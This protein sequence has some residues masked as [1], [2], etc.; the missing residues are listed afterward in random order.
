MVQTP[1]E[2]AP[3]PGQVG[4]NFL[5]NPP[6]DKTLRA[7]AGGGV[8]VDRASHPLLPW[9]LYL[10]IQSHLWVVVKSIKGEGDF[11]SCGE[12]RREKSLMVPMEQ[13]AGVSTKILGAEE[14]VLRWWRNRK[15][16]PLSPPQIHQKNI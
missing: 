8:G 12:G 9:P 3:G 16:R 14:A 11:D 1:A 5:T 4:S 6:G 7:G 15:G 2:R 13:G 10:W